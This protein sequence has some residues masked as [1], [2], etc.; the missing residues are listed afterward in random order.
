M[1]K[2][3][4]LLIFLVVWIFVTGLALLFGFTYNWPDNVHV[5]YGLPLTWGTNTLST[6]VGPVD[7]WSVNILNLLVDLIFWL[8]IMATIVAV[9]LYKL[10]N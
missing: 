7:N 4:L 5:N 6:L 9:L 10:Q 1:R 8:G 2:K 3:P